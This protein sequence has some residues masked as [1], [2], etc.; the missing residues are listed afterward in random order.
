MK[1][2]TAMNEVNSF[3]KLYNRFCQNIDK[4][5]GLFELNEQLLE[6]IKNEQ[7][8]VNEFS[9]ED[10]HNKPG[11]NFVQ[12]KLSNVKIDLSQLIQQCKNHSGYN[13]LIG[14]ELGMETMTFNLY[15][16]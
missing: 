7:Q 13:A 1:N 3:L 12:R 2:N 4:Y 5:N 8:F 14:A 15:H 9:E 11:S 6:S 10:L 16:N